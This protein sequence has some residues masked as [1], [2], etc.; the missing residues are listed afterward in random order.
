MKEWTILLILSILA[1]IIG[2]NQWYNKPVSKTNASLVENREQDTKLEKE[3]GNVT[4]AIKYLSDLSS[5]SQLV[6]SLTLDTHSVNLD[7]FDFEKDVA[8]VKDGKSYPAKA[9]GLTG[10]D[11]HRQGKISFPKIETPFTVRVLNL[12]GV[13]VREFSFEKI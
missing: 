9:S 5:G 2:I 10:A 1:A 8:L 12:S 11:H 6:F 13:P 3:A 4:V 7:G